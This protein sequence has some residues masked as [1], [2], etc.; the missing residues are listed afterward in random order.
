MPLVTLL[1][2]GSA[3][4]CLSYRPHV[5]HTSATLWPPRSAALFGPTCLVITRRQINKHRLH[6][7]GSI[8]HLVARADNP[9]LGVQT[10]AAGLGRDVHG[11]DPRAGGQLYAGGY[12]H[13]LVDVIRVGKCPA[14]LN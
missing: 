1:G 4:A 9:V 2:K 8:G 12:F 14:V 3:F 11:A 5:C 10:A 7:D 6:R 13:A